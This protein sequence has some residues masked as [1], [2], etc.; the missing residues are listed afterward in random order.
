MVSPPVSPS[1]QLAVRETG[2]S[3]I[4]LELLTLYTRVIGEV[5][6]CLIWVH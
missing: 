6:D 3:R 5:I 1:A 4:A 2:G